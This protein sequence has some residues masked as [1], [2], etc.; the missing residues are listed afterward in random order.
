MSATCALLRTAVRVTDVARLIEAYILPNAPVSDEAIAEAGHYEACMSL[1]SLDPGIRGA[2]RGGNIE[3]VRMFYAAGGN[4]WY[5]LSGACETG[6]IDIATWAID[7]GSMIN[8][9]ALWTA[10]C[11][12]QH[13]VMRMLIDHG[14]DGCFCG[15]PLE[16]HG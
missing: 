16:A 3:I 14:V 13:A 1:D 12:R 15:R 6:Q 8:R 7:R 5:A 4:P 11:S 2:A 10:C 9:S